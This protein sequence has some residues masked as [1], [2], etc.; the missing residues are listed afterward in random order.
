MSA[1]GLVP[2]AIPSLASTDDFSFLRAHLYETHDV[3]H[4]VTGFGTSWQAEIG[5]QAFYL[6]QLPAPLAGTLLAVGALRVAVYDMESRHAVM[7]DIARG[8]MLG[9]R[10]RPLFGVRWNDLWS[11]PLEDVRAKLGIVLEQRPEI[12]TAYAA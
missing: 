2:E 7:D 9:K 5:L 3:W 4:V 10:A 6:A 8:W 11:L 12:A 1:N